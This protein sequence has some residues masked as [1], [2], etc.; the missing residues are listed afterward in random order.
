VQTGAKR[1]VTDSHTAVEAGDEAE[2]EAEAEAIVSNGRLFTI[3]TSSS[4]QMT[5]CFESL[6]S[7]S[8]QAVLTFTPNAYEAAEEVDAEVAMVVGAVCGIVPHS[9]TTRGRD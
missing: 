4:N 1:R 7:P 9:L 2:E 3:R 8:R 6:L 5:A